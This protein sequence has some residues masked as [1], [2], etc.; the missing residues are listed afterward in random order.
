MS[1]LVEDPPYKPPLQTYDFLVDPL[2]LCVT[3]KL[4][5]IFPPPRSRFEA[6]LISPLSSIDVLLGRRT[7]IQ[8]YNL[9]VD[10]QSLCI[11]CK[12]HLIFPPPRRR[13]WGIAFFDSLILLGCEI[14]PLDVRIAEFAPLDCKLWLSITI[15][16]SYPK[17]KVNV[18]DFNS[19]I[20]LWNNQ[21]N[22]FVLW[23]FI[24]LFWNYRYNQDTLDN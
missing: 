1:S 3:C 11:A 20:F 5:L 4:N 8:T 18:V 10:R 22:V 7:T 23:W 9:L 19:K 13:F 12:L 21:D 15:Y 24:W 6:P 14:K 16:R 2:S 17:M